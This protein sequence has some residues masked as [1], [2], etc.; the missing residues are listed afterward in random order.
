MYCSMIGCLI[1]RYTV[2][3]FY[4]TSLYLCIILSSLACSFI[5]VLL[6]CYVSIIIFLTLYRNFIALCLIL[7]V[8][9]ISNSSISISRFIWYLY[10]ISYLHQL[11]KSL[12]FLI[13]SMLLL[14][15]LFLIC[16]VIFE[17]LLLFSCWIL[18]SFLLSFLHVILI[19]TFSHISYLYSLI[20]TL[21]NFYLTKVHIYIFIVS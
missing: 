13:Y 7:A 15:L 12:I 9:S 3:I 18:L 4:Y 5:L 14:L 20:F 6:L 1:N 11:T 10:S 21:L 8:L 17:H 19:L 2:S 16:S